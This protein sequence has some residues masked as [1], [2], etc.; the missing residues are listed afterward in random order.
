MEREARF[1]ISGGSSLVLSCVEEAYRIRAICG[2]LS[3]WRPPGA[4]LSARPPCCLHKNSLPHLP[5]QPCLTL[6]SVGAEFPHEPPNAHERP[7][8]ELLRRGDLRRVPYSTH[9]M[10]KGRFAFVCST[11]QQRMR[12]ILLA[13]AALQLVAASHQL[14]GRVLEEVGGS[15]C[16]VVCGRW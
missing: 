5:L 11:R 15:V 3:G 2:R 9:A 13:A 10:P 16:V 14:R 6:T 4:A 12:L 8:S 7:S 1:C